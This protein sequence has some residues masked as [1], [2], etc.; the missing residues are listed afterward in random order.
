MCNQRDTAGHELAIRLRGAGHL[1]ARLL[2]QRAP[3]VADVHSDLLEDGAAHHPGLAAALQAMTL[4]PPPAPS[5]E[6]ALRL[7][8]LEGGADARLQVVKPDRR[9]LLEAAAAK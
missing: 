2:A 3:H 4:R 7:E 5:L 6:A 9:S 1:G 8:R